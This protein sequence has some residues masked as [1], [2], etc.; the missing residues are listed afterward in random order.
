MKANV[1]NNYENTINTVLALLNLWIFVMMP[2]IANSC[3]VS[4]SHIYSGICNM[5]TAEP[6]FTLEC[7]K[8]NNLI[9]S[10]EKMKSV[11]T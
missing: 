8:C 7:F 5:P 2:D 10:I 3:Y 11:H 1:Q 9:F 4:M 6:S